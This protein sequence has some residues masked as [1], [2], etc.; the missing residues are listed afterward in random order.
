MWSIVSSNWFIIIIIIIIIIIVIIIIRIIIRIRIWETSN[1]R[2]PESRYVSEGR[3]GGTPIS[4][5][6]E[7]YAWRL[8]LYI[9]IAFRAMSSESSYVLACCFSSRECFLNENDIRQ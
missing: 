7:R 5:Y 6:V 3:E 8:Q 4:H 1:I 2:R 9:R